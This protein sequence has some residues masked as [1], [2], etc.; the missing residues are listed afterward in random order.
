MPINIKKK[1]RVSIS[2]AEYKRVTSHVKILIMLQQVP[3]T[4]KVVSF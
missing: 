3:K 4:T 2:A 1:Y